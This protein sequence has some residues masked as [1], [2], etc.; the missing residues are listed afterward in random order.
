MLQEP[1]TYL[2]M[3]CPGTSLPYRVH[4]LTQQLTLFMDFL[5][6]LKQIPVQYVKLQH[7]SLLLNPSDFYSFF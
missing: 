2:L 3:A 5:S 4:T 1:S 7:F 6:Y